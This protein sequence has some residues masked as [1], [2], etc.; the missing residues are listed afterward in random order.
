MCTCCVR[1]DALDFYYCITIRAARSSDNDDSNRL[2]KSTTKGIRAMV[3]PVGFSDITGAVKLVRDIYRTSRSKRIDARVLE[4]LAN[5]ALWKRDRPMTGGGE[6][7]VG[8]GEIAEITSISPEVVADS[9]ERMEIAGKVRQH[10]GTL[11]DPAP[12]WTVARR[13]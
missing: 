2:S 1:A 9:L 6:P 13:W 4:T 8:A 7:L 3:L 12:Y 5:R 10:E 11:D